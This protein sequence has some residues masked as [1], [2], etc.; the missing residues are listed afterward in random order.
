MR[1]QVYEI[2][3]IVAESLP[4][5][6][7]VLEIGSLIVEGQEHLS[8]RKYFPEAEYVGV[9]MQQGNGVDVVEDFIDFANKCDNENFDGTGYCYDHEEEFDLILCLDMLEHAK[10][11]FEVIE[12]AKQCLKPNGVLLVTS[13]FNFK[14]HEY[15]N[16]YWRFTPECFKMLLGNNCRVYKIGSDLMPHTVI[17]IQYPENMYLNINTEINKYCKEQTEKELR[18]Q[19]I[20]DYFPPHF[21]RLYMKLKMKIKS[22]EKYLF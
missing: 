15:P 6:I 13:V 18:W 20:V 1:K 4:K 11:P 22:Y 17:G 2:V 9:D 12:S 14:I 7:K 16:D 19:N 8:V 3:K 5:K 10:E 21:I